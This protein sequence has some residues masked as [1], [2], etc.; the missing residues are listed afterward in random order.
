MFSYNLGT[1]I[2]SSKG[3]GG[4]CNNDTDCISEKMCADGTCME[5]CTSEE[6]LQEE[7]CKQGTCIRDKNNSLI[8]CTQDQHCQDG[9]AC[10][11][12]GIC[13]EPDH[14]L[15]NCRDGL[16]CGSE[17]RCQNE[18]CIPLP[19]PGM[20]LN[21]DNFCCKYKMFLKNLGFQVVNQLFH[22]P[23]CLHEA[24][25]ASEELYS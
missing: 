6:C 21:N 18:K 10:S 24:W 17:A 23:S 15:H 1:C 12:L 2:K 14:P 9:Y 20:T 19:N 16:S 8:L 22:W 4:P 13:V 5:P 7:F 11:L 25:S 3:K